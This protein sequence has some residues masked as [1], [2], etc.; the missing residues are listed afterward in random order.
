[1]AADIESERGPGKTLLEIFNNPQNL[2]ND[3][4]VWACSIKDRLP[5]I[6]LDEANKQL[7]VHFF[8]LWLSVLAGS[9]G[10]L[11]SRSSIY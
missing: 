11:R 4:Y 10:C 8:T 7:S 6:T 2:A 5:N 9:R 1:M 3:L